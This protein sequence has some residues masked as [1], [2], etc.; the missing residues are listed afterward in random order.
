MHIL[1]V[2]VL[3]TL[4][5]DLPDKSTAFW[6]DVEFDGN[7]DTIGS[8]VWVNWYNY[9]TLLVSSNTRKIDVNSTV[10]Q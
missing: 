1:L 4:I 2:A 9:L 3:R 6:G 8:A 7:M 5:S 10:T